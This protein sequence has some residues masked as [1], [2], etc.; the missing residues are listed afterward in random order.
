MSVFVV[1]KLLPDGLIFE[2]HSN[3]A[4]V[5]G[6]C[7]TAAACHSSACTASLYASSIACILRFIA[8]TNTF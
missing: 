7:I 8:L 3:C 4:S 5:T 1:L 2:N 6:I